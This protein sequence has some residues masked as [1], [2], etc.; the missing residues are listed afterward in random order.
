MTPNGS[1]EPVDP[2]AHAVVD[3]NALVAH[4]LDAYERLMAVLMS[5]HRPD[6]LEIGITMPQAKILY[7]LA[8]TGEL[9]LSNLVATLGVSLSTVSG[10]VDRLV[11]QRLV[12]RRDDP[13]DRRQVLVALTPSGTV[14]VERFRELNRTQ[15]QA[16]LDLLLDDELGT[17]ARAIDSLVGAASRQVTATP[18][19][20]ALDAS[21]QTSTQRS[22]R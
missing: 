14:L 13:A 12:V 11:E 9:H 17:V 19:A 2:A 1:Y 18:P 7:L 5:D 4:T 3:R 6:F 15:L 22:V 16:L 21:V 20:G 10:I 8:A